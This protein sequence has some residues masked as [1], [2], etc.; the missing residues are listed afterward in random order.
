VISFALNAFA[1]FWVRNR[2]MKRFGG[3][4]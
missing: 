2:L 4:R 1:E 3:A